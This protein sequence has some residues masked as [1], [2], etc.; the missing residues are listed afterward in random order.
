MVVFELFKPEDLYGTRLLIFFFSSFVGIWIVELWLCR[1]WGP[2]G[3]D[4]ELNIYFS[5]LALFTFYGGGVTIFYILLLDYYIKNGYPPV[6]GF[7]F[8]GIGLFSLGIAW[9][10]NRKILH[11]ISELQE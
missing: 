10:L 9:Y 5:W 3:R 8:L 11:K 4:T 1:N 6:Y 2:C 7:P